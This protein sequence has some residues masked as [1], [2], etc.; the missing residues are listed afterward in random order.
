MF[1]LDSDLP[2]SRA[3]A[4]SAANAR[5]VAPVMAMAASETISSCRLSAT[6]TPTTA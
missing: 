6:A 2:I 4:L 5:P 3:L 1:S